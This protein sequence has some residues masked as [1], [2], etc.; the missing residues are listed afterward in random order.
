MPPPISIYDKARLADYFTQHVP[1]SKWRSRFQVFDDVGGTEIRL[2]WLKLGKFIPEAVFRRWTEED[3]VN[4]ASLIWIRPHEPCPSLSELPHIQSRAGLAHLDKAELARRLIHRARE[5]ARDHPPLRNWI[6]DRIAALEYLTAPPVPET[7]QELLDSAGTQRLSLLRLHLVARSGSE[8][9]TVA[10]LLMREAMEA[11]ARAVA[12]ALNLEDGNVSANLMIPLAASHLPPS[13]NRVVMENRRLAEELWRGLA[14]TARLHIVA[15][16]RGTRHA[17]FWVPLARGDR[18]LVL[19]GAPAAY[20]NLRGDAVFKDDL[21]PLTGF[22][23]AV[24]ARWRSFITDQFA[25]RMFV[26][27]PF[28]APRGGT[29]RGRVVMCVLNVNVDAA[30]MSGWY[31]ARHPEWL[32]VARARSQPFVEIAFEALVLLLAESGTRMARLDTGSDLLDTLP[33]IARKGLL[34]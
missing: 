3:R 7:P 16:T 24:A 25:Q 17:G 5:L 29:G 30:D 15:E 13:Q 6:Q 20:T 18:S 12:G 27:L 21:P 31:R 34:E 1:P 10:D 28:L 22:S 19:P 14:A 2:S 11:A 4:F 23:D 8:V 33:E 26:S 9:R 32:K